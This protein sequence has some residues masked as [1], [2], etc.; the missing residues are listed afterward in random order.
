LLGIDSRAA[1]YTWTAALVLLLFGVIYLIRDTILVFLIA[2][3]LA[4]L[5]YPLM[6]FIDRFLPPRRRTEAL[7]ITYLLMIGIL[8]TFGVFVGSAVAEQ[9]TN[10]A[11]QTPAFLQ[12]I[13]QAPTPGPGAVRSLK[14]EIIGGV[15]GQLTQH[16]NEIASL[17]PKW[18]LRVLAASGNLLYVVVVPIL[19]FFILR[20]GRT[21]RDN[22]LEMFDSH[23]AAAEETLLDIHTLLLQYMRALFFLC[24]AT[25]VAFSIALSAMGVPYSLL[26][27]SIAFPLEFIP[28]VGPLVA[29][30]I[31]IVVSILSGFPH[32]LW[33]VIFLGLYRM[34]QDYV[35]SPHLMSRGVEIHPLL[36]IFGVF[37]GGQ[38]GGAVGIFL[39]ISALALMRLLYHGLERVRVAQR[40]GTPGKVTI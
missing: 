30:V 40:L 23:R 12:R 28:L 4:Y 5:L 37:A 34:F 6:D 19:S 36:V 13:E 3:L 22:F 35:L 14:D 21:I 7:A 2:L 29:A 8:V 32:V 9:A 38:I 1:R 33:V 18:T 26:L 20:D 16:Y 25:F 10:L 39:S 17:V 11:K 24:C 27:A 31:I 15:Q